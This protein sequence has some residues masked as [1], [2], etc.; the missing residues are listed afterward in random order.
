M[1]CRLCNLGY[2]IHTMQ[3]M[4]CHPGYA[5]QVQSK[6][7]N[8]GSQTPRHLRWRQAILAVRLCNTFHGAHHRYTHRTVHA[9]LEFV[10]H[11]N[12]EENI[13][14]FS[15]SCSVD[16]IS[17]MKSKHLLSNFL[18]VWTMGLAFVQGA[19]RRL[20]ALRA[21]HSSRLDG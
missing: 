5:I 11:E 20:L 7:C 17:H 21:I 8:Q 18:M 16:V 4:L 3:S 15:C 6:L 14:N 10:D 2:A 13:M 19:T 9:S 12:A 1:Q